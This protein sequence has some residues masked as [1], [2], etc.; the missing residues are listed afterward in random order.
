MSFW[1]LYQRENASGYSDDISIEILKIMPR[2]KKQTKPLTGK[3]LLAKV[4]QLSSLTRDEKAKACGYV[5]LEKDGSERI[6][7]I[8]FLNALLE[9]DGM[10]LDSQSSTR[11]G[12]GGRQAT[13]KVS[14][15]SNGNLLVAS[16]YTKKMDAKPGD[17]FE[18]SVGRKHINLSKVV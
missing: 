12:I 10:D 17:K 7:A 1:A 18:I 14:V 3:D 2:K 5:S 4:E 16:A 6:K 15:Q 9:A 8:A 13:Y 11:N